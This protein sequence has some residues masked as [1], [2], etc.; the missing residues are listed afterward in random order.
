[1]N[2]QDLYFWGMIAVVFLVGGAIMV[3][4]MRNAAELQ[5][6]TT[7]TPNEL[8]IVNQN[9][10]TAVTQN[11]PI[12]IQIPIQTPTPEPTVT[13]ISTPIETPPPVVTPTETPTPTPSP[14]PTP[15]PSPTPTPTV[16][17]SWQAAGLR[18][19]MP[20]NM[21]NLPWVAKIYS[22]ECTCVIRDKYNLGYYFSPVESCVVE[23]GWRQEACE[24]MNEICGNAGC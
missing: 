20:D 21:V 15:T 18:C 3:S 1:M 4:G 7:P 19:E 22:H 8:V 14:T 24:C 10:S 2:E 5:N 23:S 11:T 17:S 6:V 9:G 16:I 12:I 13:I